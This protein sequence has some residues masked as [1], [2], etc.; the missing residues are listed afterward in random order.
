MPPI[1]WDYGTS[2]GDKMWGWEHEVVFAYLGW[3][4][5]ELYGRAQRQ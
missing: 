5:Q 2:F 3:F 1:E 4:L